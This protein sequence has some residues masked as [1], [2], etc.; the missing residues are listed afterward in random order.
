MQRAAFRLRRTRHTPGAARTG[1]S[2]WLACF[3]RALRR[4]ESTCGGIAEA[5]SAAAIL[6][7]GA[8][9][10]GL[11]RRE[12]S[13]CSAAAHAL[14]N[15]ASRTKRLERRNK[16]YAN[17]SAAAYPAKATGES[18]RQPAEATL[19]AIA[20]AHKTSLPLAG[21]KTKPNFAEQTDRQPSPR[22][23][24]TPTSQRDKPSQSR[25]LPRRIRE[26]ER[27]MRMPVLNPE[28]VW[29]V[30]AVIRSD[31]QLM[32]QL[33]ERH[34]S[35]LR[36]ALK[37]RAGAIGS[38]SVVRLCEDQRECWRRRG[39]VAEIAVGREA[40]AAHLWSLYRLQRNDQV[41]VVFRQI[42]SAVAEAEAE[43]EMEAAAAAAAD[44]TTDAERADAL[45][46]EKILRQ[47]QRRNRTQSKQRKWDP[48]P[49][50]TTRVPNVP[51]PEAWACLVAARARAG[52][53]VGARRALDGMLR[54]GYREGPGMPL[55]TQVIIGYLRNEERNSAAWLYK[56][57]ARMSMDQS[58]LLGGPDSG[59][60][61]QTA[62]WNRLIGTLAKYGLTQEATEMSDRMR[63]QGVPLSLV[64][65]T[66]LVNAVARSDQ[67]TSPLLHK[68]Y[69]A[70]LAS[71]PE[72]SMVAHTTFIEQFARRG[73]VEGAQ[74]VLQ[75]MVADGYKPDCY[76]Y[77]SLMKAYA[78]QNNL[79]AIWNVY[80]DMLLNRVE[81][82]VITYT[83]M[84]RWFAAVGD[85]ES[86]A[87][88]LQEMR[89][90]GIRPNTVTCNTLLWAA[91]R[92]GNYERASLV[93]RDMLRSGL[94]P[95]T[96][97][98]AWLFNSCHAHGT[99]AS[100]A[101]SAAASQAMEHGARLTP[102][103][104]HSG[105]SNS[106]IVGSSLGQSG[107]S[108][109]AA[110]A[111]ETAEWHARGLLVL[112]WFRD[113]M[114]LG[115]RPERQSVYGIAI[116]TLARAEMHRGVL[117]AYQ[118]MLSNG[119]M[120]NDWLVEMHRQSAAV[121]AHQDAALQAATSTATSQTAPQLASAV[122]GDA[123]DPSAVCDA[124]VAASA[125]DA[126]DD[127]P[128][129]QTDAPS[130]AHDDSAAPFSYGRQGRPGRLGKHDRAVR[131][132]RLA[133]MEASA[134]TREQRRTGSGPSPW[135]PFAPSSARPTSS[136][137]LAA[138]NTSS[139]T[140]SSSSSS[141]PSAASAL[142][143]S[144]SCGSGGNSPT[145]MLTLSARIRARRVCTDAR[146]T[147]T[148]LSP[149][150]E[151][152]AITSAAITAAA[153]AVDSTVGTTSSDAGLASSCPPPSNTTP[154]A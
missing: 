101:A 47:R 38:L 94:S 154:S 90:R 127:I 138:S 58:H 145:S 27:L 10:A 37:H 2:M 122:P 130:P 91:A 141:S 119:V 125:L 148:P 44:A 128:L 43:L 19:S 77:T 35:W 56:Q 133:A 6:P 46:R 72:M 73:D 74:R 12:L 9:R 106:V 17:D 109:A 135:S 117:E 84:I 5:H 45:S 83:A 134:R 60:E 69:T 140:S 40:E 7:A 85:N 89:L 99:I 39:A 76:S 153:H 64:T 23:N 63:Q 104:S 59:V 114:R 112:G 121:V 57:F 65:Q 124:G 123:P 1:S 137:T 53:G 126:D 118:G 86:L 110:A 62:V 30:Y 36:D 41:E 146:T 15:A 97:T 88:C 16:H 61:A 51:G 82:N 79:T 14:G 132:A 66:V 20:A 129:T 4:V 81:L 103:R 151:L 50:A 54:A 93:Y 78:H 116:S 98:Y 147:F 33:T 26:L 11:A 143:A 108:S 107:T 32:A 100:A 152:D 131:Q 34:F 28:L 95:D 29:R 115:V 113:M 13:T 21:V 8:H 68:L 92:L 87:V 80:R 67:V 48:P 71:Y 75:R 105:T 70:L 111:R 149:I 31:R 142:G 25:R 150:L 136:R 18:E 139:S 49:A 24:T 52:D 144:A 22:N 96:F 120:P 102:V 42:Q 55:H 3:D